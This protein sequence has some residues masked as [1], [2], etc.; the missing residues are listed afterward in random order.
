[1]KADKIFDMYE[2]GK[3]KG[4]RKVKGELGLPDCKKSNWQFLHGLTE[5]MQ[6]VLLCEIEEKSL[7]F[8]EASVKA[9]AIKKEEKVFAHTY[10]GSITEY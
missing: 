1:M 8:A 6:Y 7:S 10:H 9:S 4:Q 2:Q 5:E 3:V